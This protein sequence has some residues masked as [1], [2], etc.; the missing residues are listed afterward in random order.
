MCRI[1]WSL[2]AT[3]QTVGEHHG[4]IHRH[5]NFFVLFQIKSDWLEQTNGKGKYLGFVLYVRI[6]SIDGK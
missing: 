4:E 6:R 5:G 3:N 2:S 1:R